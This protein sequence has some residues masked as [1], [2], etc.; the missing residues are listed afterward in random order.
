MTHNITI[1]YLRQTFLGTT[2]PVYRNRQAFDDITPNI[3][4]IYSL[5]EFLRQ[6]MG[7]MADP[8]KRAKLIGKVVFDLLVHPLNSVFAKLGSGCRV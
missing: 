5:R 3:F 4:H 7:Q 2:V 6:E 8:V 1:K